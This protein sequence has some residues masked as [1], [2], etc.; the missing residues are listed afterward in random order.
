MY[1]TKFE[2]VKSDTSD[3]QMGTRILIFIQLHAAKHS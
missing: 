1:L 2:K 3:N